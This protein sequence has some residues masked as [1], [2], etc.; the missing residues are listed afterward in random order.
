MIQ[1]RVSI[2]LTLFTLLL[3][4]WLLN[5]SAI[6]A[7]VET[8]ESPVVETSTSAAESSES[9]TAEEDGGIVGLF[10]LNWKL[11]LGQLINFAIILFVLWKWVWG[12]V[13]K[14]LADRTKKIED[15]LQEAEAIN[16][17]RADFD[18]WKEGEIATVRREAAEIITLAKQDAVALRS[19]TLEHTK[20]EQAKLVAQTEAKLAQEKEKL[21][22]EARNE[23]SGLIIQSTE[24]ILQEKLNSKKDHELI[25]K[26]LKRL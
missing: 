22:S 7:A 12:P 17:D 19:Q 11:F 25:D 23:I 26:A 14:G 13:T 4:S 5:V 1:R 2:I 15:S 6:Q 24:V 3:S 18:A 16:K 20:Q 21:I 8:H 9:H 10:G